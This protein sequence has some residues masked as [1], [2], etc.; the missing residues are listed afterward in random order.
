MANGSTETLRKREKEKDVRESNILAAKAVADAVRT[1][2]G[3]RGMD[4]MIQGDDGEVII[5]NDG[6]TIL[7]KMKCIHP[8]AKMMQSLSKSQDIEAGDGTTSVVVLAGALLKSTQDLLSKGIHPTTIAE[9]FLDASHEAERI[10]ESVS[11]P[12]QL[13][14]REALI[15]A[16]TTSLSSKVVSGD[17][18]VLAPIAV[19]AT[20]RVIDPNASSNVD[21]DENIRV[22]QQ[23][24]GTIED[25][26]LVD[27]LV[28]RK[29]GASVSGAPSRVENAKIGLIQ[30]KYYSPDCFRAVRDPSQD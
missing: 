28:F 23:V 3:P 22:V 11:R 9:A 13:D 8:A 6:A 18:Q 2:L 17:S 21:I 1:S 20:L 10:L 12:V 24:G 26:E 4:K 7:S 27:G 25:T 14:D 5:T 15:Q 19:D 30:C 16:A 29:K